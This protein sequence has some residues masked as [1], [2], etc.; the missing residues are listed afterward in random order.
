MS[1]QHTYTH[2]STKVIFVTH[3]TAEMFSENQREVTIQKESSGL[4]LSMIGG[5]DTSPN[6][7]HCLPRIGT[8]YPAGAAASTGKLQE[9][10]VVLRVN[11][12][13]VTQCTHEVRVK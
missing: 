12:D 2:S 7:L 8:L 1:L 3:N 6:P 9:G 5:R 11:G 4:G 13:D 10:D